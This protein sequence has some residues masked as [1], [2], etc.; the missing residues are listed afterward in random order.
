MRRDKNAMYGLLA[1]WIF[2]IGVC[3]LMI[4]LLTIDLVF[5]LGL[6]R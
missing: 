1:P 6:S 2:I 3:G 4:V 5:N